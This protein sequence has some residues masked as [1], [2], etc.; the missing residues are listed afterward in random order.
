MLSCIGASPFYSSPIRLPILTFCFFSW[1][2]KCR[3]LRGMFSILGLSSAV[4]PCRP[5]IVVVRICSIYPPAP[6]SACSDLSRSAPSLF[7]SSSAGR[8]PARTYGFSLTFTCSVS[9][10]RSACFPNLL[11]CRVRRHLLT[12]LSKCS[13]SL[14]ATLTRSSKMCMVMFAATMER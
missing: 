7:S 10:L 13:R 4:S 9:L 8:R 12:C 14:T 6:T 2:L 5:S 1:L 11:A 3:T